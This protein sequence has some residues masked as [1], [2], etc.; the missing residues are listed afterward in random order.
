MKKAIHSTQA[1]AAI[2]PYSQAIVAGNLCFVSGQ[3]GINPATGQMAGDSVEAQAEQAFCNLNAILHE[4]GLTLNHAV[5]VTVFL[6]D[7]SHFATVN[8]VYARHFSEPYPARCAFAVKALPA[9]GLVEIDLIATL[10]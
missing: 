9:G 7:M 5:K 3:L 8:Q 2:G 4:A 6:T 10:P 1:P